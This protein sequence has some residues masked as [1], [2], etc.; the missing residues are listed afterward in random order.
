MRKRRAEIDKEDQG[1]SWKEKHDKTRRLLKTDPL[2]IK[3]KTRVVESVND[4]SISV[5]ESHEKYGPKR[6]K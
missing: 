1:L 2:W 5:M 4:L 3:L 6:P